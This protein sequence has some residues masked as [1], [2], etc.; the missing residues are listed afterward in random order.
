VPPYGLPA[1][2]SVL[3]FDLDAAPRKGSHRILLLIAFSLVPRSHR[4]TQKL[5]T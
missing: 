3:G 2:Y 4:L 5:P 1:I